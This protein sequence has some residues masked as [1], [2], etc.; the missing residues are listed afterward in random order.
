MTT[1]SPSGRSRLKIMLAMIFL[2]GCAGPAGYV[3][4]YGTAGAP[5]ADYTLTITNNLDTAYDLVVD[6]NP[7]LSHCI[8]TIFAKFYMG[9]RQVHQF[10]ITVNKGGAC[11]SQAEQIGALFST[12]GHTGFRARANWTKKPGQFNWQFHAVS[13]KGMRVEPIGGDPLTITVFH[14]AALNRAS[15]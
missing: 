4:T 3:P 2:A 6:F 12:T 11:T 1:L 15:P 8:T 14:R 13:T 9:F 10:D 5:P 7:S